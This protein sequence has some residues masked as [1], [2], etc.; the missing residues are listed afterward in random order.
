MDGRIPGERI[1]IF[2]RSLG[3]SIGASLATQVQPRALIVESA[4]TSVPEMA[5]ELYPWLPVR[6]LARYQYDTAAALATVRCPVL[7]VHSREDEIIPYAHGEALY[8]RAGEPKRLL[9]LRGEHNDGFLVSPNYVPGLA[10]FLDAVLPPVA[11]VTGVADAPG[12][13]PP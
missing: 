12:A 4:F 10:A 6:L 7:V 8:A 2:G 5:A 13:A 3:A 11:P 9:T 1:V